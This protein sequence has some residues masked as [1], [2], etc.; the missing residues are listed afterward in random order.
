MNLSVD[1][2]KVYLA[3]CRL[4][5]NKMNVIYSTSIAFLTLK[6]SGTTWLSPIQML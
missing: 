3:N 4:L 2:E 5:G 6:T 1:V